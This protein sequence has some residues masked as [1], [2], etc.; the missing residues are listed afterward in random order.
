MNIL[1]TGANRG[2][3]YYLTK[4]GLEKGHKMFAGI[5]DKT[6][7]TTQLLLML[8]EEYQDKLSMIEIDVTEEST[9]SGAV[10]FL[11]E[12]D[13]KVDVIINNAGILLQRDKNIEDLDLDEVMRSFDINTLG[14]IRIIKHFLPL[15]MQGENQSII[16]ISSEAGSITNAYNPDYPYGM[17][18]VALNML[19]EKLNVY[20]KEKDINVF[21]IHPGW[22]KTDMGGKKAPTDPSDTASNIF[23]II[24]RKVEVTSK[25]VFIDHKGKPMII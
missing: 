22:M 24:E 20:L 25:Y 13:E 21:A 9:I 15:L 5:R 4:I 7:E 10:Q 3:G 12:K 11:K 19:S 8:K 2:L 16:N 23:K 17:S 1:L 6:P 14:P 18:K